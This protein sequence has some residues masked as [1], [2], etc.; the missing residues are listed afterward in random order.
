MV[1]HYSSTSCRENFETW[2]KGRITDSMSLG[3]C[4]ALAAQKP[5]TRPVQITGRQDKRVHV[6]LDLAPHEHARS[7]AKITN[8]RLSKIGPM[9]KGWM[10]K[11]IDG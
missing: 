6:P 5:E 3:Y 7:H 4:R 10:T 8:Q 11:F 2:G 1:N 9:K